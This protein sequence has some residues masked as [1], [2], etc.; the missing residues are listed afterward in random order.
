MDRELAIDPMLWNPTETQIAHIE[1]QNFNIRRAQFQAQSHIRQD[2]LYRL[3]WN[4][5]GNIEDI[6][7]E[8][9]PHNGV[10]DLSPFFSHPIAS[11]SIAQP[12][13]NRLVVYSRECTDKHI[14]DYDNE[15]HQYQPPDPLVIERLD[16][17]P[18]TVN[19]FVTQVH[20]Y[21]NTHKEVIIEYLKNFRSAVVDLGNGR[22]TVHLGPVQNPVAPQDNEFY[23]SNAWETATNPEFTPKLYVSL[24]V[25]GGHGISLERFWEMQRQMSVRHVHMRDAFPHGQYDESQDKTP[26]WV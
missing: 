21:L 8:D 2:L 13:L 26:S 17:N 16:G 18:I 24:Y 4:V 23:F 20:Y 5:F 12:P 10:T 3:R 14:F 1:A 7:I 15:G 11:D 9:G 22:K 19:D 25:V 6:K